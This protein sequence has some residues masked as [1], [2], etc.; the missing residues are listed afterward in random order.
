MVPAVMLRAFLQHGLSLR[1]ARAAAEGASVWRGAAWAGGAM[2]HIPRN[3]AY[4]R[5]AAAFTRALSG[6]SG[7]FGS[8]GSSSGR[9]EGPATV[10]LAAVEVRADGDAVARYVQKAD[11]AASLGLPVRDLRAVDASFRAGRGALLPRERC[12]VAHLAHVR[13]LIL[14]DSVLV[15]DPL[16]PHVERF[17]PAL[18]ARLCSR[19]H[20]MPFEFRALEA[21]LVEVCAALA[22]QL[23][24]VVPAVDVVLDSLSSGPA[25]DFAGAGVTSSLDRLLPLENALNDFADRVDAAR[26]AL[27]EVLASDVRPP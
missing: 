17:V 9:A 23:G 24:G 7:S 10:P 12:I 3:R 1:V 15:F 14:S 22:R 6:D 25:A 18:Q 4:A 26:G 21:V 5:D 11:A 19:T 8:A 13:V 2:C 27:H 20:P 16:N